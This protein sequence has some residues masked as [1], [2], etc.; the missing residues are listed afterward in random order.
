MECTKTH[1]P[2]QEVTNPQTPSSTEL[3]PARG[4]DRGSRSSVLPVVV[5]AGSVFIGLGLM[6]WAQQQRR[7]QAEPIEPP[8]D[9]QGRL[10]PLAD[11]REAVR[12]MELVTM[13]IHGTVTKTVR[14]QRW[15]GTAEATIEAPVTYLYGVDLSRLGEQDVCFEPFSRTWLIRIPE[16]KRL[17][18]EVNPAAGEDH[19]RVTGTRFRSRAGEYMLS[20]A[21]RDLFE[22]A[23]RGTLPEEDLREIR[24]ES[25]RRVE[26]LAET[27]CGDAARVAVAFR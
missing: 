12:A 10:R 25:R 13:R 15:R 4:A 17:A 11:V 19:V 3:R 5:L 21:R 6:T 1:P 23:C 24:D 8:L 7:L 2:E 27:V 14:D 9:Q 26:E 18:V 22:E 20:L 16:P